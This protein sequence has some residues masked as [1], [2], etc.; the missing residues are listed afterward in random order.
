VVDAMRV[1]RAGP[2]NQSVDFISFRQKK[3]GQIR[4]ILTRYARNQRF[5][6]K[7]GTHDKE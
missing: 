5:H 1:E 7:S 3:F 4:P 6:G 2:P